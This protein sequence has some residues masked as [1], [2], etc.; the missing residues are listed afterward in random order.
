VSKADEDGLEHDEL[1]QRVYKAMNLDFS[2]FAA[3]PGVEFAQRANTER[4]FRNV[5]A[6]R[7]YRD[8]KRGWR[9]TSPNLEQSGLLR[10]EYPSLSDLCR[11]NSHWNGT[12]I[13]LTEASAETR[14]RICHAL[15]DYLRRELAIDV[16]YLSAEFFER[17]QQ[18]SSQ[19][20]RD[21]WA[22][23]EQESHEI[24]PV[25]F[26]R[27]RRPHDRQFFTYVSGR[28]GFGIYL[29]RGQTLPEHDVSTGKLTLA[30]KDTMIRDLFRVLCSAG[31]VSEQIA[32]SEDDDDVPG[33][34]LK[35]SAMTW[36]VADGTK[37][38]HDPIR[39]PNPPTDGGRTNKFFVEFYQTVATKLRGLEAKEHTA[40][41]PYQQREQREKDF[42]SAKLPVLYCS[43]TMEL[44]VDIRQLNVVNMRNVPPLPSRNPL[45]LKCSPPSNRIIATQSAIRP[46]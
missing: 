9:I 18:Q 16:E 38:F 46:K 5:L 31:F 32:A 29:G 28:S 2:L 12:H 6:Y 27:G 11:S 24:T 34:Q 4:A 41:V 26:P 20:L 1:A 37:A 43:P 25:V 45:K 36:F 19:L 10:I 14:E 15:L 3:D 33:Y 40:Q 8:Q 42:G 30:D 39:V 44:G 17:L 13:A 22:I 35:A 7:L 21:P 23:D